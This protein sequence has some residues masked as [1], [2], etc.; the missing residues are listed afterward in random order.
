MKGVAS[1]FSLLSTTHTI[2]SRCIHT[3]TSTAAETRSL[4]QKYQNRSVTERP[5]ESQKCVAHVS[6][7]RTAD[8]IHIFLHQTQIS[9]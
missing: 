3:R 1:S 8:R 6:D 9:K 5:R 2:H 4:P 7:R